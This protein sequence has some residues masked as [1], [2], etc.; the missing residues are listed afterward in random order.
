MEDESDSSSLGEFDEALS[1]APERI[2]DETVLDIYG[3][4]DEGEEMHIEVPESSL[5]LEENLFSTKVDYVGSGSSKE[6]GSYRQ[7][8]KRIN[9]RLVCSGKYRVETKGNKK[10]LPAGLISYKRASEMPPEIR[11][12]IFPHEAYTGKPKA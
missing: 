1:F 5:A 2:N 7:D 3:P 8:G 12:I 6:M 9:Y 4:W 10:D 11:K